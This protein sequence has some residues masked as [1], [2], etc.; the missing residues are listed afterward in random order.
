M[1]SLYVVQTCKY[2]QTFPNKKAKVFR[3]ENKKSQAIFSLALRQGRSQPRR[4]HAE[5]NRPARIPTHITRAHLDKEIAIFSSRSPENH[6]KS[7]QNRHTL[8]KNRRIYCQGV[9][10]GGVL[11]EKI[12]VFQIRLHTFA[13]DFMHFGRDV[14]KDCRD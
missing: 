7:H 2:K 5:S 4:Q 13:L 10:E 3:P 14:A 8:T 6:I 1:F 11:M 9:S 12:F